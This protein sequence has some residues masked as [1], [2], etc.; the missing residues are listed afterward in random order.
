MPPIMK[1]MQAT[2]RGAST[3]GRGWRLPSALSEAMLRLSV[4]NEIFDDLGLLPG[5][6][7]GPSLGMT[8]LPSGWTV[9]RNC[10][11][12]GGATFVQQQVCGAG[13]SPQYA[14]DGSANLRYGGVQDGNVGGVA[15]KILNGYKYHDYSALLGPRWDPAYCIYM[16]VA[17][18]VAAGSPN[19]ALI[20]LQDAPGLTQPL[21]RPVE[22]P[23]PASDPSSTP[24]GR[25]M[26][27]P[28]AL[29]VRLLPYRSFDR[30]ATENSSFGPRPDPGARSDPS[31]PG[32][33]HVP[34]PPGPGTREKKNRISGGLGAVLKV[35]N[36]IT[37]GR[38]FIQAV[39]Q[40]LPK[41]LQKGKTVQGMLLDIY[42]HL[43]SVDIR[44]AVINVIAQNLTD[45]AWAK[46]NGL[47][48]IEKQHLWNEMGL[49]AH[50]VPPRVL[51]FVQSAI[52]SKSSS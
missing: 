21:Y 49:E 31:S 14:P 51:R 46:I 13:P 17:P 33:P 35:L 50:G 37:E 11:A 34:E 25:P 1:E 20:P 47:S 9:L 45:I 5:P 15:A 52:F 39:W 29:P 24:L 41:K 12:G 7:G 43:G 3:I 38:D 42:N 40:A 32:S 30:L 18:W 23:R 28:R 4:W 44:K 2:E 48:A 16:R 22:R 36:V 27:K 19:P 8:G 26:P 6:L 10:L